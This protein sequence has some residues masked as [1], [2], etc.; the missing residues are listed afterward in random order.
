M[1]EIE[2]DEPEAGVC[3]CCGATQQILTRYVKREDEP[4]AIYK[5]VLT[6]QHRPPRA[7]MIVGFGKWDEAEQASERTAFTFEL[8]SDE[9]N[10]NVTLVDEENSAW[11]SGFL[12]TVLPREQALRH[13]LAP[14]VF[15][16]AEHILRCDERLKSYLG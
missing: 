13:P 12:G 1:D 8:W 15:A 9:Q 4:F 10:T 7:E 16:L 6:A 5:A 11:S 2:F 14:E 3:G